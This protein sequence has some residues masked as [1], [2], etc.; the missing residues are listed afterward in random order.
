VGEY[1]LGRMLA[2]Q[3]VR[4]TGFRSGRFSFRAGFHELRD[5]VSRFEA[6]RERTGAVDGITPGVPG[7]AEGGEK[8]ELLGGGHAVVMRGSFWVTRVT[9]E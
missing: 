8:L 4:V 9:T 3:I 1:P 5:E 2:M 7:G 6:E